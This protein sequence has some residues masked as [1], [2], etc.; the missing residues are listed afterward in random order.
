MINVINRRKLAKRTNEQRND[1]DSRAS[2]GGSAAK[3]SSR[4]GL[5][6]DPD[7]NYDPDVELLANEPD[8]DIDEPQQ[9]APTMAAGGR[10][11]TSSGGGQRGVVP[12]PIGLRDPRTSFTKIFTKQYQLRIFNTGIEARTQFPPNTQNIMMKWPYHD[13]PVEYVGFYLNFDE[14]KW[15]QQFSK[16][17]A[18]RASVQLSNNTAVMPFE[19]NS[20][21]TTVGNN[22]VGVKLSVLDPSISAHRKGILPDIEKTI[23]D[24]FWGKH[25]MDIGVT[26]GWSGSQIHNLGAQ[27]ITRN[28]DAR[29]VYINCIESVST[30]P[31][32][33]HTYGEN[34]F[35]VRDYIAKRIN[36]SMNEGHFHSW[37]HEFAPNT[38]F[39]G[40]DD[41]F[42]PTGTVAHNEKTMGTRNLPTFTANPRYPPGNM[43]EGALNTNESSLCTMGQWRDVR[44]IKFAEMQFYNRNVRNTDQMPAI[45]FGLDSLYSA[46]S[47]EGVPDLVKAYVEVVV[48]VMIEVEIEDGNPRFRI[49]DGYQK[50]LRQPAFALPEMAYLNT[51]P[52]RDAWIIKDMTGYTNGNIRNTTVDLWD[53]DRVTSGPLVGPTVEAEAKL[54]STTR[55][56]RSAKTNLT[57]AKSVLESCKN[58]MT[59][60]QRKATKAIRGTDKVLATEDEAYKLCE[61]ERKKY[62]LN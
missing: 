19:T 17:I 15:C 18:K 5:V 1:P 47:V 44:T 51:D 50:S 36:A 57:N 62:N 13:L 8:M 11:A 30:Q 10:L 59:E 14:M 28:Y 27:Y 37:E 23:K 55:E 38:V 33:A 35:P 45:S 6:D 34:V 26:A 43:S 9:D 2:T 40:R 3:I 22:N 53:Y 29:Y 60:E 58:V 20:S 4:R 49:G 39:L 32:I 7:F 46:T 41:S 52:N 24:V 21:V 16:C 31:E 61:K 25:S 12:L 54:S 48:D 42:A 56:L